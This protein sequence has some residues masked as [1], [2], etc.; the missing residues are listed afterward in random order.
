LPCHVD[1]FS[2]EGG[3]VVSN[4]FG[5]E[6]VMLAVSPRLGPFIPEDGGEI[7]EPCRLR[8]YMHPMFYVGTADRGSSLRTKG[9][10][11]AA[12]VFK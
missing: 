4:S 8:E 5:A 11:V 6:L 10:L 9:Y 3:V 7:I 1:Y 12:L 2:I